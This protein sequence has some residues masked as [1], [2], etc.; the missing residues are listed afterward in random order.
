MNLTLASLLL[1]AQT[2]KL[3]EQVIGKDQVV[4]TTEKDALEQEFE[5]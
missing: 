3:K 1:L 2:F 5:V 4:Y